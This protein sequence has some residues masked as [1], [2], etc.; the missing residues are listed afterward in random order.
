[1]RGLEGFSGIRTQSGQTNWEE[2]KPCPRFCEFYPGIYLTTEEKAWKNLSQG[3]RR[4]QFGK[5]CQLARWK[6][7]IQ[8]RTYITIKID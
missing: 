1:M 8:N 3:S 2:C 6:Q 5:K 7:N 4:V